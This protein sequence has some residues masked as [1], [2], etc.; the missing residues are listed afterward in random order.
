MIFLD[1]LYTGLAT[2][3]VMA[4]LQILMF[5]AFKILYPP[6][7]RIIYRD[8]PQVQMQPL[9]PQLSPV[10]T[11]PPPQELKLP[12]YEPRQQTSDSLRLDPQLPPGIKETR[13]PGT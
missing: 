11:E 2:L 6:P 13:P 12:D 4:I 1:V 8:V 10:L 3:C 9:P 5:I 7:P